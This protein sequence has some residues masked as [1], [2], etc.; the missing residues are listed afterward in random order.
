ML[1]MT[2]GEKAHVWIH[3]GKWGF[4]AAGKPELGIPENAGLE[5]IIHLKKFENVS[6]NCDMN[7]LVFCFLSFNVAKSDFVLIY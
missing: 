5:F 4:G 3:P 6:W 7:S 1:K 2:N